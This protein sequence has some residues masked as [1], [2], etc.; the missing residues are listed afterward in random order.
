MAAMTVITSSPPPPPSLKQVNTTHPKIRRMS[1]S[2]DDTERS[3]IIRSFILQSPP[4]ELREVL[5]LLH[6]LAAGDA[7]F[8]DCI[9]GHCLEYIL[10]HQQPVPTSPGAST[11]V[12]C[13]RQSHFVS[14]IKSIAKASGK[15]GDAVAAPYLAHFE[16]AAKPF[17]HVEHVFFDDTNYYEIDPVEGKVVST[18][19]FRCDGSLDAIESP[20]G[21]EL[22]LQL[23]KEMNK[24]VAGHF[25]LEAMEGAHGGHRMVTSGNAS[26]SRR[27]T[28]K[29]TSA[30]SAAF[31][32]LRASHVEEV[33]GDVLRFLIA[34][35]GEKCF[36]A[37][38]WTGRWKALYSVDVSGTEVV[39]N[40][41]DAR[42][43]A[44]YYE[45]ANVQVNLEKHIDE[46]RIQFSDFS[47]A[48]PSAKK[49]AKRLVQLIEEI[50]TSIQESLEQ[51]G[52]EVGETALKG[53]RRRL[54]V[55]KELFDVQRAVMQL[56]RS[57]N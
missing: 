27:Q 21:G 18:V 19:P 2:P 10:R 39:L 16:T 1:H 9:P 43:D 8:F 28:K 5:K 24:Y 7:L 29:E 32:G 23:I 44:H 4:G 11:C 26:P 20:G 22:R 40:E 36:P 33:D 30:C 52:K 48:L 12:L 14:K 45:D 47:D 34:V 15:P 56:G 13:C 25:S 31:V 35:T 17:E 50:E 3:A 6:T 51:S 54:P 55:T 41:G 57:I 42:I 53:L 46:H 49:I 37:N 38:R